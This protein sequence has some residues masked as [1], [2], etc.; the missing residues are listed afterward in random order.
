MRHLV[1]AVV[2]VVMT[3]FTGSDVASV[4]ELGPE[5]VVQTN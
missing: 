1:I 2:F 5:F 4:A 3:A